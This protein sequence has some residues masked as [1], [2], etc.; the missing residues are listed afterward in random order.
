M[1]QKFSNII[2]GMAT[3]KVGIG[4][5]DMIKEMHTQY[6]NDAITKKELVE[7]L[8]NMPQCLYPKMAFQKDDPTGPLLQAGAWLQGVNLVSQAILKEDK[9]EV[10]NQL[11]A[12]RT[13]LHI[14][15]NMPMGKE[16][17]K[18]QNKF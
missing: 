7:G 3:M 12:L 9:I 17:K 6:A 1:I 14:F 18:Q 4:L 5:M 13:R 15:Y 11:L 8:D 2:E 16:K 10:A